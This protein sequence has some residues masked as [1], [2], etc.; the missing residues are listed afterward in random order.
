MKSRVKHPKRTKVQILVN[1]EVAP[2]THSDIEHKV[3]W[4]LQNYCDAMSPEG[5]KLRALGIS[6]VIKSEP[7]DVLLAKFEKIRKALKLTD[8]DMLAR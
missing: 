8:A 5:K 3:N 2:V 4:V 6:A 7:A 1:S